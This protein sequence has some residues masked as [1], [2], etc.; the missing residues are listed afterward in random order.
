MNKKIFFAAFLSATLFFNSCTTSLY[1]A[2]NAINYENETVR[3]SPTVV[4]VQVDFSNKIT[5]EK[6]FTFMKKETVDIAALKQETLFD[7]VQKNDCDM[8]AYPMYQIT[9]GLGSIKVKIVGFKGTFKN[10]RTI[11]EDIEN[12]KNINKDDIEKYSILHHGIVI[13]NH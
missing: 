6:K 13:E 4:D 2:S 10:P 8:I 11:Y 1:N 9:K 3:I 7:C 12:V 5:F